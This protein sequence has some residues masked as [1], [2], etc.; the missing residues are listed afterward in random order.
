[1]PLHLNHINSALSKLFRIILI[2]NLVKLLH[3]WFFYFALHIALNR[4]ENLQR[5]VIAVPCRSTVLKSLHF[6][7]QMLKRNLF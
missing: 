1:M 4:Q 7:V 6:Q 2:L 5:L 3:L